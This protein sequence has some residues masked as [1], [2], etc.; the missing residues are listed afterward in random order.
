MIEELPE[1][2]QQR[3]RPVVPWGPDAITVERLDRNAALG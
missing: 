2:F 1:R 3:D